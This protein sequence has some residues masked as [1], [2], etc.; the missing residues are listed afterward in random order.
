[1]E[2]KVS[3]TKKIIYG[4]VITATTIT[5]VAVPTVIKATNNHNNEQT[6]N[7]DDKFGAMPDLEPEVEA[8]T[9]VSDLIIPE[10]EREGLEFKGWFKDPECTMPFAD[11]E[12]VYSTTKVYAKWELVKYGISFNLPQGM[13]FQILKVDGTEY[14][15]EELSAI[16]HGTTLNF[17]INSDDHISGTSYL[18]TLTNKDEVIESTY[19][20]NEH[21]YSLTV[22]ESTQISL[23]NRFEYTA[24]TQ[25]SDGNKCVTITNYR[26]Y[27]EADEISVPET[28]ANM[29]VSFINNLSGGDLSQENTTIKTVNLSKYVENFDAEYMGLISNLE[30]INIDADNQYLSSVQ[31]VVLQN[32]ETVIFAPRSAVIR[33]LVLPTSVTKI[34]DNA[35]E[36]CIYVKEINFEKLTKLTTIGEKAFANS[37]IISAILPSSISNIGYSAFNS[38]QALQ[39][40]YINKKSGSI[41]FDYIVGD[42]EYNEPQISSYYLSYTFA[43]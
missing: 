27:C 38:C 23:E 19:T 22:E 4:I 2:K 6:T 20:N 24:T 7:K 16:P 21:I 12:Y 17:R 14:T 26:N 11:D 36:H 8:G 33:N 15:Q 10:P 1:M 31:G 39:T 28:I 25:N 41:T 18:Y 29:P 40:I 42:I 30:S 9:L 34:G 32:T 5:A 37:G 13:S 35:F 43:N 3:T